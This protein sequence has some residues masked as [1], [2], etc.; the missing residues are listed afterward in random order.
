MIRAYAI[1]GAIVASVAT[2]AFLSFPGLLI[3]A[4]FI[5][6]AGFHHSG[7]TRSVIGKTLLCLA[8]G[9]VLAWIVSMLVLANSTL[10]MPLAA[11]ALVALVV[12][13]IIGLSKFEAFNIVPA[14]FYGFASGFAFLTQTPGAFS[15]A[16]LTHLGLNNV[17]IV[18]PVSMAIGVALGI[19]QIKI[20]SVIQPTSGLQP[21]ARA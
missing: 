1:A 6:W 19:V 18:V 20:A 7:G 12:P 8:F 4:A 14:V 2:W 15:V 3:W 5:A 9:V 16:A 11:A 13:I 10:P 17:L 21:E